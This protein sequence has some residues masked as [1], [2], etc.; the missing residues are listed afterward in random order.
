MRRR[1]AKQVG[2]ERV[3]ETRAMPSSPSL[4]SLA[5]SWDSTCLVA[6]SMLS[7][8]WRSASSHVERSTRGGNGGGVGGVSGGDGVA[9]GTDGR[10]RSGGGGGGVSS[11]PPQSAQSVPSSHDAGQMEPRPPS[12]HAPL[13]A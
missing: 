6:A 4:A 10:A 7:S 13:P 1:R 11:R 12:W 3:P 5:S 2:Q 8:S 9:G